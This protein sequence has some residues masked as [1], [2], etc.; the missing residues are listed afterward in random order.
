MQSYSHTRA[1]PDI[2]LTTR[3][4]DFWPG[5]GY[6]AIECGI[7]GLGNGGSSGRTERHAVFRRIGCQE[8]AIRGWLACLHVDGLCLLLID[9]E[10]D[11]MLESAEFT[12]QGEL[13]VVK[14]AVADIVELVI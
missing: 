2:E 14:L 3:L 4:H 13:Q 6:G 5:K 8:A 7:P 1:I 12:L 10:V 9:D 11:L